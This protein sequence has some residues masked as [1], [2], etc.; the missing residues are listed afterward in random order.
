MRSILAQCRPRVAAEC[1]VAASTSCELNVSHA[2]CEQMWACTLDTAK[3]HG[4]Q[5]AVE[6]V[7][8]GSQ[9]TIRCAPSHDTQCRGE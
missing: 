7:R 3:Q 9:A 1:A 8:L 2:V 6:A 5:S 4:D